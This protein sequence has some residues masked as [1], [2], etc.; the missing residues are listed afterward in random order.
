MATR[1]YKFILLKDPD[2]SSH[3]SRGL[4]IQVNGFAPVADVNG[5]IRTSLSQGKVPDIAELVA[6]DDV[7]LLF[8]D[9]KYNC[10]SDFVPT[11][12]D[13][14]YDTFKSEPGLHMFQGVRAEAA[15]ELA[16]DTDEGTT[17][18]QIILEIPIYSSMFGDRIQEKVKFEGIVLYGQAYNV[19]FYDETAQG[20]LQA[21][22]PVGLIWFNTPYELT[23]TNTE[24]GNNASSSTFRVAIGLRSGVDITESYVQANSAYAAAYSAFQGSFHVVN[25]NMTTTSAFVLRGRDVVPMKDVIVEGDDRLP[26]PE[27]GATIDF[28]SRVFFT[29]DPPGLNNDHNVDF[30]SP[31]R[32]TVFNAETLCSGTTRIPQTL[33]GKVSYSEDEDLYKHAY[34]DGVAESYYEGGRQ[35][36]A[37]E[38]TEGSV[39]D[40]DWISKKKPMLSIFSTENDFVSNGII[41]VSDVSGKTHQILSEGDPGLVD[42]RRFANGTNILAENSQCVG[43]GVNINTFNSRTRGHAMVLNSSDVKSIT[44]GANTIE[45]ETSA[46]LY[47]YDTFVANSKDIGIFTEVKG[48]N[49]KE[50]KIQNQL[51]TIAGSK[52]VRILNFYDRGDQVKKAGKNL[53]LGCTNS[54]LQFTN[55]TQFIGCTDLI[56]N[57]VENATVIGSTGLH[58]IET[59]SKQVNVIGSTGSSISVSE[60]VTGIGGMI[61]FKGAKDSV[62]VSLTNDQ[63]YVNKIARPD[64]NSYLADGCFI[65]GRNNDLRI[66]SGNQYSVYLIGEGLTSDPRNFSGSRAITYRRP[67]FVL[68]QDNAT[69]FEEVTDEA[70]KKILD[71]YKT[72]IIGGH[73]IKTGDGAESRF[74]YNSLEH[75]VA[76]TNEKDYKGKAYHPNV[77]SIDA[78]MDVKGRRVKYTS[79]AI[80]LSFVKNGKDGIAD[81]DFKGFGRINLF[82]L[83]QLLHRMYWD[84]DGVVRFDWNGTRG[85]DQSKLD[86]VSPWHSW[87]I[88]GGRNL[89]NLV[90]DHM[91]CYPY[92]PVK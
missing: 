69:Y 89:A 75:Y 39:Y 62:I 48:T 71:T 11:A 23:P 40:I 49:N 16:Y 8:R 64:P 10:S 27:A 17:R 65:L 72:I 32:L 83:Y 86:D 79:N 7:V 6:S 52:S 25:N 78:L 1:K 41:N 84:Y 20:Q 74:W 91:C 22:V 38:I 61:S 47:R 68:G 70:N 12:A 90:D 35:T 59:S 37:N 60:R 45:C 76:K 50:D 33:I 13:I 57:E 63:D 58:R 9:V 51:N 36:G 19:D 3:Q 29:N 5:E 92:Y 54:D 28:A 4:S 14:N 21:A 66:E 30:G 88:H 15:D 56:A 55:E 46:S 80:D 44:H 2:I 81:Y 77:E 24:E 18:S 53:V 82:K 87:D 73:Y 26:L 67:S 42:G 31:A 34:W 43:D 85:D